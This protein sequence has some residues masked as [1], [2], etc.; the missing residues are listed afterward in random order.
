[1]VMSTGHAAC[2]EDVKHRVLFD[3]SKGKTLIRTPKHRGEN[4]LKCSL[5]TRGGGVCF[6]R[7]AP[8][9]NQQRNFVDRA[10]N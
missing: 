8:N 3:K 10:C 5:K 1:M 4:I 9:K 2:T 7:V 6:G